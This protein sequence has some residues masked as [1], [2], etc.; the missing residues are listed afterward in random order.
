MYDQV[1]DLRM[2]I[3]S[4]LMGF[5][6]CRVKATEQDGESLSLKSQKPFSGCHNDSR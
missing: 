3:G 1:I 4:N 6:D 5:L 2:L